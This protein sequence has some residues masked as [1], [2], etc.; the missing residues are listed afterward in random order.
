MLNNTKE[1]PHCQYQ[2]TAE[3]FAKW[4]KDGQRG[5]L[6]KTPEGFIILL[7]PQCNQEI[8]WDTLGN[9]F[10]KPEQ[11]AKSGTVFNLIFFGVIAMIIY[12]IIKLIF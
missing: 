4:E 6:G 10:L 8:K 5:L 12:G 1:C 11:S 7:C 3:G 9:V 2:D